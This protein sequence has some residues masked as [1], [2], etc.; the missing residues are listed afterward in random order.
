MIYINNRTVFGAAAPIFIS[1]LMVAVLACG[2]SEPEPTPIPPIPTTAASVPTSTPIPPT[3]TPAP[4]DTPIP[5]TAT[6]V[7]TSTPIPPTAIPTPTVAPVSEPEPAS[8][9]DRDASEILADASKAFAELDSFH[10]FTELVVSA[11]QGG[12]SIEFP[13]TIQA[14]FQK[15]LDSRGAFEIALGFFRIE[16]QF[17]SVDGDFYMTDPETGDW[18]LGASASEFLPLNPSDLA[19]TE[20]FIAPELLE[21]SDKLTLEGVEEIQGVEA[22]RISA[23]PDSGSV[24]MLEELGGELDMT[25][26]VGVEDNLPRRIAASGELAI[27]DTGAAPPDSLLGGLA[28][29]DTSFEILIEYSDFDIPVRIE[30][31]EEFTDIQTLFP[32]FGEDEEPR[33]IE[34]EQT[35]LDSGWIM[36]DLPAEGL[37]IST[38]PSWV[39]LP[40]DSDSINEAVK[41]FESLGDDR[42]DLM[43]EQLEQF[44]DTLEFKLFGFDEHPSSSEEFHA[45]MSVLLNEA[46]T[47]DTLDDY[48][49]E[50]AR[51]LESNWGIRD[52]E[53]QKVGLTSG[54]AVKLEYTLPLP[55]T[56][57]SVEARITQYLILRC[58]TGVILTF[59]SSEEYALEFAPLFDRIADA[60]ELRETEERICQKVSKQYNSSPSMTIDPSKNYT[61]TFNMENGSE[62]TIKLFADKA[63]NTT[64]NFVFLA[65]DGY[66]DGVTFHRVI[67]DFMAQSGDP[68]GTG[69]GGPGYQFAD[70]FHP[71]LKHDRPGILSMA[72]A[73][74]NTNG[75]Q[76]FITFVPTPHLDNR[77]AVFGEVIEGMDVVNAITPRDPMSARTPGDAVA[78]IVINES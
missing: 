12:T 46:G 13:I 75:S 4:T 45:N 66:Y 69:R 3:A 9:D 34:L 68:T 48:A 28:G 2:D 76:F 77:H 57:E 60:V 54:E 78:S 70:E 56:G 24:A 22:Y 8:K 32:G 16:I 67:P 58:S 47:P 30:P 43:A 62:F 59:T 42:Y 52:V 15:P 64:N 55:I 6:P 72:N 18:V 49:E 38:P 35:T 29:D 20:N 36:S 33:E 25:F 21:N 19:E 39:T 1:M 27:P 31:P 5:P 10:L 73:G 40:L 51:M 26:W 37:S 23:S 14:D 11:A 50:N 17:I 65:R 63:P 71:D 74:P 61:A 41:T 7:P 44:Q 53:R